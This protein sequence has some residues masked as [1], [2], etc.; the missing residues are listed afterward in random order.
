MYIL[1]ILTVDIHLFVSYL[2]TDVLPPDMIY[3]LALVPHYNMTYHLPPDILILD[4]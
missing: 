3:Y 2:T 4:L 1:V